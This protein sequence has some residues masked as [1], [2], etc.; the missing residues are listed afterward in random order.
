MPSKFSIL[1]VFLFTKYIQYLHFGVVVSE[2]DIKAAIHCNKSCNI[3]RE[4]THKVMAQKVSVTMHPSE[5]CSFLLPVVFAVVVSTPKTQSLRHFWPQ[6]FFSLVPQDDQSPIVVLYSVTE[7]KVCL[8]F[9]ENFYSSNICSVHVCS[10]WTRA[11]SSFP[12]TEEKNNLA[13]RSRP[14]SFSVL[15]LWSKSPSNHFLFE[16]L[17]QFGK[18]RSPAR[19]LLPAEPHEGVNLHRTVLWSLHPITSLHILLHFLQRLKGQNKKN[20]STIYIFKVTVFCYNLQT[21]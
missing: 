3:A 2:S 15:C 17:S 14:D 5:S 13:S 10:A 7:L 8:S 4:S 1:C 11:G 12:Q 9:R 21:H 16:F 6:V 19:F 20:K 18:A